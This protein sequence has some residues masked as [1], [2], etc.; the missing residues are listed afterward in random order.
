MQ[1]VLYLAWFPEDP[2]R[3][4]RADRVFRRLNCTEGTAG[5]RAHC[6]WM[7]AHPLG[8]GQEGGRSPTTL[9]PFV[10]RTY[11]IPDYAVPIELIIATYFFAFQIYCDFSGYTDI[12]RGGSQLFGIRLS[13][14]FRRSY[15]A[16]SI[17]EFWSR[18]W[19]I[20]LSRLVSRLSSTS[21][22]SAQ[23]RSGLRMYLG[24]DGRLRCQRH[25][26]CRSRL[27]HRL[28]FSGLGRAERR[29]H[30]GRAGASAR[31]G[32]A[33]GSGLQAPLSGGSTARSPPFWCFISFW[34]A[35]SSSGPGPWRTQ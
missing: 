20:S 11:A 33:S 10:D 6:A 8:S 28:G 3:S 15:F 17:G 4:D 24:A 22:S 1:D 14:N 26:A 27:W 21:R 34:S 25:L 29:L 18:R 13:E 5:P 35:G 31:C 19:H 30:L 7:P 16:Q 32:I 2:R 12:A 23:N 9:R